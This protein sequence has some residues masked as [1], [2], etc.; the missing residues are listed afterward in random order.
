[1]LKRVLMGGLLG[2]MVLTA[3]H[4]DRARAIL[5]GDSRHTVSVD[6]RTREYWV[7]VPSGGNR[8]GL[9]AV[10]LLHGGMGTAEGMQRIAHYNKAADAHGVLAV[11]PQG[12][13]RSWNDGRPNTPAAQSH[14][15][16]VKF[17]SML[18]DTLS[19]DYGIDRTRV[20][21]SGLSNGGFM[22]QRLG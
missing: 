15:D 8:S 18:V 21:A 11:Y 10:F 9:P 20:F 12:W 7:H 2:A 17:I 16:D 6:G 22:S 14:V 4:F 19:A 1:M 3:C 13:R 5:D